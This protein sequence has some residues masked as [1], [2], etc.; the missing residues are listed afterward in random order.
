MRNA[1]AFF[2][3]VEIETTLN[4]AKDVEGS[5][6]MA[7]RKLTKKQKAFADNY[8]KT[9]NILQ[10]AL[11]AGYSYNYAKAQSY[12]L[13]DNV[14]IREYVTKRLDKVDDRVM[15]KQ[16]SVHDNLNKMLE[17][18][19]KIDFTKQEQ[20]T[21]K[22]KELDKEG[23]EIYVERK[24]L[25]PKQADILKALELKAKLDNM[26]G[27]DTNTDKTITIKASIPNLISDNDE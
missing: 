25:P 20:I 21:K 4:Y 2:M 11:D 26:F 3:L 24:S 19:S 10:S 9:G 13:L 17:D 16:V 23:N 12:K 1:V 15:T 7:N 27:E 18:A 6:H 22:Y 14:G 5:E 8:I